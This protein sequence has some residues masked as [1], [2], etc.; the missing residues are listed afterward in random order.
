MGPLP[1][2]PFPNGMM[3]A[4]NPTKGQ[5]NNELYVPNTMNSELMQSH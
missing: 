4:I 2:Q 5:F 3:T 1:T